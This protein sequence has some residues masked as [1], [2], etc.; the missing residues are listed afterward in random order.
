MTIKHTINTFPSFKKKQFQSEETNCNSTHLFRVLDLPGD[1]NGGTHRLAIIYFV[2]GMYTL[3]ITKVTID[4][5]PSFKMRIYYKQRGQQK[6]KK[7]RELS[8]F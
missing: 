7:C 3:S 1:D 6:D 2:V 8:H 4:T 5:V